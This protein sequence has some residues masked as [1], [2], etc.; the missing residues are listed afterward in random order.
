MTA[1]SVCIRCRESH[2]CIINLALVVQHILRSGVCSALNLC[3]ISASLR[4]DPTVT[5]W[6]RAHHPA[7][8]RKLNTSVAQKTVSCVD[9]RRRFL[10][11]LDSL[12]L[13]GRS[14]FQTL[15]CISAFTLNFIPRRGLFIHSRSLIDFRV[16][17]INFAQV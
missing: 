3:S 6:V 14:R 1:Q 17:V 15:A 4:F 16:C 2:P 12:P 13:G 11:L 8:W 9:F 7:T 5:P 10:W